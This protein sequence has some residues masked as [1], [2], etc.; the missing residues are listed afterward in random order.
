MR[1]VQCLMLLDPYLVTV[2]SDPRS[3]GHPYTNVLPTHPYTNVSPVP[4]TFK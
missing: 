4:E 1:G 3:S 2:K